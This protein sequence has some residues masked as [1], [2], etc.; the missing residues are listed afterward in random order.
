M[1]E[2]DAQDATPNP[3]PG[4]GVADGIAPSHGT[5]ADAT[6]LAE[7]QMVLHEPPNPNPNPNPSRSP[8]PNPNPNPNPKPNPNR[9]ACSVEAPPD[10]LRGR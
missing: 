6:T 3:N 9:A 5:D 7:P 1:H 8:N 4:A 2:G 10:A